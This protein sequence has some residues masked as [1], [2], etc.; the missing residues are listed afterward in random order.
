[1]IACVRSAPTRGWDT[2]RVIS[3]ERTTAGFGPGIS[4][5]NPSGEQDIYVKVRMGGVFVYSDE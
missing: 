2:C 5:W 4:Y 3:T 1:M